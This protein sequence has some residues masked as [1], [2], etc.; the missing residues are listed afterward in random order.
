M[1]RLLSIAV[2]ASLLAAAT[3]QPAAASALTPA[4]IEALLTSPE[5]HL[6]ATDGRV[7]RLIA[8]G[9]R[10]SSTFAGLVSALDRTNVIVYIQPSMALPRTVAGRTCLVHTAHGQRYLRI[11]IRLDLP[12]TETIALIGHEVRHA[13]EIAEAPEVVDQASL[14]RFYKRIGDRGD[15]WDEFDTPAARAAGH[16]VLTEL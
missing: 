11:Q 14:L 6:R 15:R 3:P 9:L 5:R 4:E 8:E 2:A 1:L 12:N 16:R 13:L 7:E 10:R